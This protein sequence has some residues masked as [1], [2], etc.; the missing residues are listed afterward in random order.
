[1][2]APVFRRAATLR[3][4]KSMVATRRLACPPGGGRSHPIPRSSHGDRLS[5][6]R[7]ARSGPGR[8]RARARAR[9]LLSALA[10]PPLARP[11]QRGCLGDGPSALFGLRPPARLS[12]VRT[13]PFTPWKRGLAGHGAPPA[14]AAFALPARVAGSCPSHAAVEG[15]PG[16]IVAWRVT[17]KSQA[18]TPPEGWPGGHP[19]RKGADWPPKLAALHCARAF[20]LTRG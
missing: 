5:I 8:A 14:W 18:V 12:G 20:G 7:R 11:L 6:D 15:A 3:V 16:A 10:R 13:I 1:M 4:A 19:V 9:S 2:G 17:T